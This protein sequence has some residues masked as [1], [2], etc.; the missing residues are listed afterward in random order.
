MTKRHHVSISVFTILLITLFITCRSESIDRRSGRTPVTI[1]KIQTVYSPATHQGQNNGQYNDLMFPET[2]TLCGE[3]LPLENRRV[4]EMLDRE[5]T[6]AVWNRRQVFLW[7]K[8]AARYF[9]YIEKQLA[10]AGMPDDLKYLAV[11]ESDL[12]TK[13]RSPVGALGYWQFMP[14]TGKRFG[15]KKRSDM[16]E[17][18][19]FEKATGAALQYLE[20]LH[21]MF[22][23]WTLALAGYNCGE[24]CV[25]NAIKEQNVNDYFRLNLPLETERF[26]FRITAIKLILENPQLYGY[27]I[28]PKHVYQPLDIDRLNVTLKR[29]VSMIA[30]ASAL[31][32]DYKV[33]KEL[34]PHIF[35]N[36]L[37][38]G[39]YQLNVPRGDRERVASILNRLTPK[40]S[41][42]TKRSKA[43]CYRVKPGDSLGQIAKKKGVS[44]KRLKRLNKLRG[45]HIEVGQ[46]LR[47]R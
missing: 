37:P 35:G 10:E 38:A 31:D 21:G 47:L 5:F 39:S 11:A 26:I 7:I 28:N 45:S 29:S 24:R 43:S 46:K 1:Q 17:R 42:R 15:L 33:I 6:I 12:Q 13:A 2:V 44:V 30:F 27:N 14:F 22:G 34:N 36:R 3:R 9:P 4:W 23:K 20:I 32:T 40:A 18:L 25:G 8:R 16:D 41:P 19:C